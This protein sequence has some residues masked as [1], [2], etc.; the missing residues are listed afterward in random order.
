MLRFHALALV[1][2]IV[3]FGCTVAETPAQAQIAPLT[4]EA[5]RQRIS[6]RALNTANGVTFNL[7]ADGRITVWQ[8]G[9]LSTDGTWRMCG[10][11][12]ICA[13]AQRSGRMEVTL[14]PN[15]TGR[16]GGGA[17]TVGAI[18]RGRDARPRR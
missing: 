14:Y 12:Q 2:G 10:P 11:T 9:R 16:I 3:V 13:Q 7:Y 6:G 1:A 8:G 15:G 18:D 17:F 4:G 5:L